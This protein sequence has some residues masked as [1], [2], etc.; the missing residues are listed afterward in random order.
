MQPFS[1]SVDGSS[2]GVV[3]NV[4][5]CE[6]V[7]GAKAKHL[8]P[9]RSWWTTTTNGLQSSRSTRLSS[10]VIVV[11][12]PFHLPLGSFTFSWTLFPKIFPSWYLLTI[13]LVPVFSLGWSLP[14]DLGCV[15][16]QSNFQIKGRHSLSIPK[17]PGTYHKQPRSRELQ[18]TRDKNKQ[19]PL[20][21]TPHVPKP[22]SCNR[23]RGWASPGSLT[24]TWERYEFY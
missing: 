16:K 23:I 18:T 12:S 10:S 3:A 6:I 22:F 24:I 19:L 8:F 13:G 11:N 20:T 9:K 17:E 4:L 15:P 7:V 1:H 5:Q 14:P 2:C 21:H